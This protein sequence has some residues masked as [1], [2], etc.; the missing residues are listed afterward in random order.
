MESVWCWDYEAL[1]WMAESGQGEYTSYYQACDHYYSGMKVLYRQRSSRVMGSLILVQT[2]L[3]ETIPQQCKAGKG[4]GHG[5]NASQR[6]SSKVC[7]NTF[8]LWKNNACSAKM[9][10]EGNLG[11]NVLNHYRSNLWCA[12]IT[13]QFH[14]TYPLGLLT[15][16]NM[17]QAINLVCKMAWHLYL[18]TEQFKMFFW[19]LI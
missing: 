4:R 18:I 9:L 11:F 8:I 14:H 19:L 12:V 15:V 5:T 3:H 16:F 1:A 13:S 17:Y 7:K 2:N 6:G 10:G